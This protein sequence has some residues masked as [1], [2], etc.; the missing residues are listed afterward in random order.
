M[1][2]IALRALGQKPSAD[3][4]SPSFYQGIKLTRSQ[5]IT[6]ANLHRRPDMNP[7]PRPLPFDPADPIVWGAETA[8][9]LTRNEGVCVDVSFA[10]VF[11]FYRRTVESTNS[12]SLCLCLSVSA[13]YAFRGSDEVFVFLLMRREAGRVVARTQ[14]R[15]WSGATCLF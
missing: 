4:W 1:D 2:R 11:C 15:L 5:H 6:F 3:C 8:S 7:C 9:T 13:M 10:S 12:L 14:T